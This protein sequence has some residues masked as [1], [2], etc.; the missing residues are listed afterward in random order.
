MG[1]MLQIK[2]TGHREKRKR[3]SLKPR[4]GHTLE[5]EQIQASTCQLSTDQAGSLKSESHGSWWTLVSKHGSWI[6]P[7]LGVKQ[8]LFFVLSPCLAS[9][10]SLLSCGPEHTAAAAWFLWDFCTKECLRAEQHHSP[11]YPVTPDPLAFALVAFHLTL[12]LSSLQHQC[13]CVFLSYIIISLLTSPFHWGLNPLSFFVCMRSIT[14]ISS[15]K[16]QSK[17]QLGKCSRF[18]VKESKFTAQFHNAK[19]N[20]FSWPRK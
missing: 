20:L 8:P 10:S 19:T 1:K 2:S 17:I 4:L 16:C 3:W 14:E 13:F 7:L 12:T 9:S 6:C 5:E 18:R 15:P 11:T